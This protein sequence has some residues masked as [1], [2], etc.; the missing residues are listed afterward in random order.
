[1]VLSKASGEVKESTF[2]VDDITNKIPKRANPKYI[3][4][5]H[6]K[7]DGW[8]IVS[9]GAGGVKEGFNSQNGFYIKIIENIYRIPLPAGKN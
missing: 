6:D 1:M 7:R 8:I 9:D 4:T 2:T 3:S 5:W